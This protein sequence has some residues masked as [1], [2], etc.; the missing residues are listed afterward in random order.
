MDASC[1]CI[2]R[3]HECGYEWRN[4]GKLGT[5]F[6]RNPEFSQGLKPT[7]ILAFSARLKRL[8][9]KARMHAERW[10]EP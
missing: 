4:L 6:V 5:N 3:A 10:N 8:R 9:E 7:M 1:G 2:V